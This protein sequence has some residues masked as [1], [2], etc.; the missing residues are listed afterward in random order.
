[1]TK[2]IE[3]TSGMNI[4]CLL[5]QAVM[6]EAE[7]LKATFNNIHIKKLLFY[8]TKLRGPFVGDVQYLGGNFEEVVLYGSYKQK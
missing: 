4:Y 3:H 8:A 2:F 1:M 5:F 6:K 7:E